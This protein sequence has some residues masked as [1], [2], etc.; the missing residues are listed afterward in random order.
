[1]KKATDWEY[2][3]VEIS[4]QKHNAK[5][6][7]ISNIYRNPSEVLDEFNVFLEEFTSFLIFIK[8]ENRSIKDKNEKSLQQLF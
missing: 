4:H 6:Y 1:M 5:K 2:L 7:I 3:C 8:N